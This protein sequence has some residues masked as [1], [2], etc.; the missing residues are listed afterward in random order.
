VDDC[1]IRKG[2]DIIL[3]VSCRNDSGATIQ[4]VQINL[5]ERLTWG[6]TAT[7]QVDPTTGVCSQTATLQQVATIPLHTVKNATLP[8]L[9]KE[10]KGFFKSTYDS[11]LGVEQTRFFQREIHRDLMAGNNSL[12]IPVPEESRISYTGHLIKIEHLIHIRFFTSAFVK[13]LQLEIPVNVLPSDAPIKAESRPMQSPYCKTCSKTPPAPIPTICAT[14]GLEPCPSATNKPQSPQDLRSDSSGQTSVEESSIPITSPATP[15]TSDVFVLGGD[16]MLVTNR[17]YPPALAPSAPPSYLDD[18]TPLPPPA[19]VSVP[20][21][22]REMRSAI[23]SHNVIA[24]KIS[25][26]AWTDFF[27]ALSANALGKIIASVDPPVDQPRI[28]VL[29]APLMN[30]GR[31]ISSEQVAAA[32]Q[33]C[34]VQH[35]AAMAQ[36]LLP[37]CTD[38]NFSVIRAVLND[39]EQTVAYNAFRDAEKRFNQKKTFLGSGRTKLAVPS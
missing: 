32:L 2:E 4:R 34:N 30:N 12:K 27:Q 38:S 7:N 3:H 35:R 17:R 26:P 19:P 36:R 13:N 15:I 1:T 10:A 9:G 23:N 25:E 18:A 21:L 37:L 5:F 39:W 20:A 8:S 24:G 14:T 22:Q 29:L 28:A 31:G 33:A 11:I 6:T 16:A